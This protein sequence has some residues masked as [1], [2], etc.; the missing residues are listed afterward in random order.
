MSDDRDGARPTLAQLLMA[1]IG[2]ASLGL[3]AADELA[4]E[5]AQK[6]G[7]DRAEMRS[8]VR[9]VTASWRREADR[10]GARRGEAADKAL[11]RLGLVRREEVDDLSLRVAQLEHRLRLVENAATPD[12]PPGPPAA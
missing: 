5:L 3:E 12:V 10:L 11:A 6:V 2:W 1:G 7:V 4:D 8:A 9:D